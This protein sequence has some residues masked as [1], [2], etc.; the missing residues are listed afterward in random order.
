MCGVDIAQAPP[1]EPDLRSNY[2]FASRRCVGAAILRRQI[3]NPVANG[4]MLRIDSTNENGRGRD[5]DD[6]SN[7]CRD[8]AQRVFKVER[9]KLQL[10]PWHIVSFTL[11]LFAL[12]LFIS[13]G[14]YAQTVEV[15]SEF[16][17]LVPVPDAPE[18]REIISPA[19]AR[20]GF[21]TFQV[22]VNASAG[23]NYFLFCQTNPPGL[24]DAK[25]FKIEL[26]NAALDPVRSPNFGVIP[27]GQNWRDYL[28]DVWVPPDAEP[29]R[30]VRLEL[31]L[32]VGEW[33]V[34][35]MELRIQKATVPGPSHPSDVPANFAAALERNH[36]QDQ[37]F[38]QMLQ[39]PEV[40][41][42]TAQHIANGW[43]A[44]SRFFPTRDDEWYLKVRDLLYKRANIR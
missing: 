38:E 36:R 4:L 2:L 8:H 29:G 16:Q 6:R 42:M 33:I 11:K 34:Y 43:T 35:P 21:A 23:T 25:L 19:V 12:A 41:L 7:G 1:E 5:H 32:K 30:R 44:N 24:V 37:A 27:D 31:Q 26:P 13:A 3:P 15:Y 18:P 22:R 10:A 28:L 20:N 17:P 40:W 9:T 14:I 39:L